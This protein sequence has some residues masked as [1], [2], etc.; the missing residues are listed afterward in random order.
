MNESGASST[1]TQDESCSGAA[2]DSRAANGFRALWLARKN[3]GIDFH[4]ALIAE[5][6]EFFQPTSEEAR[7]KKTSIALASRFLFEESLTK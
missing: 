6:Q 5:N 3:H 2:Q 4:W 7:A 1:S